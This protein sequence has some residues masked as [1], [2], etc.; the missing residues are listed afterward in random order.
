MKPTPPS[1]GFTQPGLPG[2]MLCGEETE[3]SE[4]KDKDSRKNL[5][6][7]VF[8]NAWV[9]SETVADMVKLLKSHGFT[10]DKYRYSRDSL[11]SRANRLRKETTKRQALL[12]ATKKDE[13]EDKTKLYDD[14][15]TIASNNDSAAAKLKLKGLADAG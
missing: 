4:G 12:L 14:L 13:K 1:K 8:V 7:E 11:V 3:V 10:E 15:G 9:A 5:S 2:A 6:A